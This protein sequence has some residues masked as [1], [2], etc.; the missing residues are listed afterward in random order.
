MDHIISGV[1]GLGVGASLVA[2]SGYLTRTWVVY[3]QEEWEVGLNDRAARLLQ[4]AVIA[5]GLALI[6]LGVRVMVWA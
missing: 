2:T 5:G 1:L 3:S 6:V 4:S